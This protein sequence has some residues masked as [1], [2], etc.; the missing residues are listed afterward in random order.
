MYIPF[1]L[2]K[3]DGELTENI[4]LEMIPTPE[5]ETTEEI[6]QES[7]AEPIAE[8][9]LEPEATPET[10]RI[11]SEP[12]P[13]SITSEPEPILSEPEIIPEP[14]PEPE[15]ILSEPESITSEPEIISERE[16]ES[17]P[18]EPE[19]EAEPIH[20]EPE[21]TPEPTTEPIPSEPEITHVLQYEHIYRINSE[22]DLVDPPVVIPKIIFI[23]PYRDREQHLNFFVKQMK[24]ILEDIPETHYKIFYIH[25][26][27]KREFNRGAIKNIGFIQV[28]QMYPDNYKDITL[29]F[30]DIDTV[31]YTKNFLDYNTTAGTVKH[32]Y[33]F[34]HALGGIVS[35]NAGDFEKINGYPN[36]WAW[37]FEDNELQMRVLD[38][39]LQ[40]DRSQFYPIMDKNILQ[41]KDGLQRLVNRNEYDRYRSKTYEGIDSISNLEYNIDNT[42]NFINITKFSTGVEETPEQN[43]LHD[44]RNG[45]RPFPSAPKPPR[46]R[47][48]GSMK[49]VM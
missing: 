22:Y 1:F 12:E 2:L 21:I 33:G 23:V 39:K 5:I 34:T 27:D 8:E 36:F 14:E 3:M 31:P 44:I 40:I 17:I 15:P 30:N 19:P 41:M 7:I 29:I 49:M 18:S 48:F 45:S 28:K 46:G 9:T 47:R 37:G 35:I 20:L 10:D 38:A 13:E 32:F 6:Y 42:N 25:Q 16:T 4:T 24:Y 43:T 26:Q 11:P